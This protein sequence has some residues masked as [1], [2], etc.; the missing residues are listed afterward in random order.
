[1]FILVNK[2][3]NILYLFARIE[4]ELCTIVNKNNINMETTASTK[5]STIEYN[6]IK[7]I[8]LKGE[9]K[10]RLFTYIKQYRKILVEIYVIPTKQVFHNKIFS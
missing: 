5:K 1:M 4:N 6:T 2:L 10:D 8:F 9:N 7:R 3:F